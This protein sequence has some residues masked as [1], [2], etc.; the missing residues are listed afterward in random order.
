VAG[1]VRFTTLPLV[2]GIFGKNNSGGD[3]EWLLQTSSS[4]TRFRFYV[5][6]GASNLNGANVTS[7][8]AGDNT[9]AT[10][11][12]VVAWHDATANTINIQVNNGTANSTSYTHGAFDS[13]YDLHMGNIAGFYHDGDLDEFGFWKKA[14]TTDEKTWLYNAGAGRSYADIVS[15]AGGGNRRRRL[16]LCGSR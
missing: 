15:E 4:S 10:W 11:Y 14:L 1:W 6:A 2:A 16:L 3:Y 8:N 12:F 9:T 7:D 13:A 5:A